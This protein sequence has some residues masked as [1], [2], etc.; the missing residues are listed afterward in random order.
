[1]GIICVFDV[2]L[3]KKCSMSLRQNVGTFEATVVYC[4]K[5]LGVRE[6]AKIVVTVDSTTRKL[7]NNGQL[8]EIAERT[9]NFS[10]SISLLFMRNLLDTYEE[11]LK[12]NL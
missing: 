4:M 5:N 6:L 12:M 7:I 2:E 8:G 1:M 3:I 10:G 9:R 11:Y